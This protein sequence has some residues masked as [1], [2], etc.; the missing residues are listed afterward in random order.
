MY[1]RRSALVAVAVALLAAC[2]VGRSAESS[3]PTFTFV[4]CPQDV[5]IQLLV[6]H[7]CA[8]LMVPQ[9]RSQP[10]GRTLKLFVVKIP[11]PD[12]RPRPDSVLI[13]GGE[14][15]AFPDYG[16][17]QAEAARFHRVVYVFDQR[18]TGHSRPELTCPEVNRVST[19][20]LVAPSGDPSLRQ[21]FLAAVSECRSRLLTSGIDPSNFHLAAMAADVDDLRR[22][23]DV[24][25]W[26]LAAYGSWSRLAFEVI[27]EYPD[28]VRGAYLD[29]PQLPQLDEPTEAALGT[30]IVLNELFATCWADQRCRAAYPHLRQRWRDAVARLQADPIEAHTRYG[31]VLVDGG[32]F[33]RAIQAM[34]GEDDAELPRFP[35]LITEANRGRVDI[36]VS[37]TLATHGSLCTGYR[38]GCFPHFSTGV[39][40]SVLCRDEAPFVDASALRRA[41]RGLPGLTEG[42]GTSP[43]LAACSVWRVPPAAPRLHAPVNATVPVLMISGQF[44]PFSPPRLTT[45]LGR[46][47]VNSFAIEVPGLNHNPFQYTG[48]QVRIRDTWLER[49]S[50]PPTGTRCLRRPSLVFTMS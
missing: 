23:L 9:D 41:A 30:R 28:H 49:P 7:S 27:R 6:R 18:G 25:S 34:L 15:G 17:L 38:Y 29:S 14:I 43:Y 4:K 2:T 19:E 44:D 13:L 36:E 10:H 20:G 37:T 3:L 12:E 22:A 5:Q 48:C 47:L 26:N 42:L 21:R 46:S 33:V 35:A 31:R 32:S 11:P 1:A 24:A 40:L 8:Y 50:S 45:E 16:K 39:Y